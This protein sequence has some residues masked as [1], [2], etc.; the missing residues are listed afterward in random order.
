MGSKRNGVNLYLG[1]QSS[2][3]AAKSLHVNSG[4]ESIESLFAFLH[5]FD[6]SGTSRLPVQ[7]LQWSIVWNLNSASICPHINQALQMMYK[8]ITKIFKFRIRLPRT[9]LNQA[10][11]HHCSVDGCWRDVLRC[12]VTKIGDTMVAQ[13][14]IFGLTPEETQSCASGQPNLAQSSAAMCC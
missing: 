1:K 12:H 13:L 2:I 3:W 6:A 5:N 8:I 14:V 11:F 7:L 4:F 10:G 9:L